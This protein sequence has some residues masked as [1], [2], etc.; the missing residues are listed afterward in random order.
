[1]ATKRKASLKKVKKV[2]KR[3]RV[4]NRADRGSQIGKQNV[5]VNVVVRPPSG[6]Q[7][8]P[9]VVFAGGSTPYPVP[10]ANNNPAPLSYAADASVTES[11]RSEIMN[12]FRMEIERQKRLEE[13]QTRFN[14]DNERLA[15]IN[16]AKSAPT[17]PI[18][19]KPPRP[20]PP[21]TTRS[22]TRTPSPDPS[23]VMETPR[24]M[25]KEGV[26]PVQ[27]SKTPGSISLDDEPSVDEPSESLMDMMLRRR[28]EMVA[29]SGDLSI[30][31][32]L[33]R[34]KEKRST[35]RPNKA[36]LPNLPPRNEDP[37]MDAVY[38]LV[39]EV[40]GFKP[41][42]RMTQEQL[43]AKNMSDKLGLN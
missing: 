18:G 20:P 8:Q 16:D 35:K 36:P 3:R 37:A 10:M 31:E 43:E 1:M 22:N 33:K 26:R 34:V 29:K 11:L 38:N 23:P 17:P 21:P 5:R 28:E 4:I 9:R 30:E 27:V 40:M 2:L 19:G 39:G 24:R 12:D 14:S 15:I 6:Q 7:Q 25:G 42:N 32:K 13:K 41:E